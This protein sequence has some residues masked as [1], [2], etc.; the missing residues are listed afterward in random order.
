MKKPPLKHTAAAN[1]ALRGPAAS[2]HLPKMAADRP[3]NTIAMLK[4][5]PSVVSFQSSGTDSVI[6]M[7]RV[8]GR[9]NTL[10]AYAW[11]MAR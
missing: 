8:S 3:R 2:S 7:T 10:K 11:P 9:L 1:M 5:Q 6:P 4:I